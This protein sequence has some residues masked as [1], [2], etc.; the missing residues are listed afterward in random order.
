[1]D[2]Q[3]KQMVMFGILG[4]L[5]LGS[6][7]YYFFGRDSGGQNG[8]VSQRPPRARKPPAVADSAKADIRKP[9]PAKL[10]N[11]HPKPPRKDRDQRNTIDK[12]RKRRR[13]D[14]R[15]PKKKRESMIG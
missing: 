12:G 4:A 1:M 7:S 15:M 6:G 3:K 11:A 8:E 9:R 13:G 5:V 2:G 14:M 10:T